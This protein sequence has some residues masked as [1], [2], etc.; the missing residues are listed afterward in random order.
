MWQTLLNLIK[1]AFTF[2]EKLQKIDATLKEHSQS[3]RD[4]T[5][6]QQRLPLEFLLQKE[7]DAHERE[8]EKLQ[9]EIKQLREEREN[10]EQR[11]L[12]PHSDK[13]AQEE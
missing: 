8:K 7:R 5:A 12:P 9:L 10:A 2:A 4:L 11:R 6:N 13:K 1:L 3:I